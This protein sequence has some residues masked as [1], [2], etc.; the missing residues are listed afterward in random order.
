MPRNVCALPEGVT[1]S[2]FNEGINDVFS[3]LFKKH[4]HLHTWQQNTQHCRDDFFLSQCYN[5]YSPNHRFLTV[6]LTLWMSWILKFWLAQKYQGLRLWRPLDRPTHTVHL[7]SWWVSSAP[8]KMLPSATEQWVWEGLVQ[9]L[10]HYD[11]Q[12]VRYVA[13][14]N[15]KPIK[16]HIQSLFFFLNSFSSFLA[17]VKIFYLN[18]KCLNEMD[19]AHE[20]SFC[21]LCMYIIPIFLF[22]SLLLAFSPQPSTPFFVIIL[23]IKS[24]CVQDLFLYVPIS[25]GCEFLEIKKLLLHVFCLP[26]TDLC[27]RSTV[28]VALNGTW[29]WAN[30]RHFKP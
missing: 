30:E 5:R 4:L 11:N 29:A 3:Y 20:S 8:T 6:M 1:E 19:F 13:F 24:C 15:F 9:L 17:L 18:E 2:L 14:S 7:R 22:L 16:L 12:N 10:G 26:R 21:Y 23:F 28:I 25:L 27:V